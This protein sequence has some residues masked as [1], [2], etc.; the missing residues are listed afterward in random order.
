MIRNSTKFVSYKDLKA[1]CRDL[2]EVYSA[3]NA[4]SGHEALEPQ[5]QASRL[6]STTT[7]IN[8]LW[9]LAP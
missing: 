9:Q 5:A 6:F 8:R 3:I 2:K 7:S 1:V 4:E